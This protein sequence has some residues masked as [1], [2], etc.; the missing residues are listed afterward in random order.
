MTEFARQIA[1][2]TARCWIRLDSDETAEQEEQSSVS[3]RRAGVSVTPEFGFRFQRCGGGRR[4]IR[5]Q[6][7]SE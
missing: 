6:R 3:V 1:E 2:A 4:V 5:R 7:R